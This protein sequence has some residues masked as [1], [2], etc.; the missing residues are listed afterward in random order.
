MSLT[1]QENIASESLTPENISHL[2]DTDLLEFERKAAFDASTLSIDET[3]TDN[4]NE[5]DTDGIQLTKNQQIVHDAIVDFALNPSDRW[6][7]SVA[8]YAGTGKTTVISKAARHILDMD[9]DKRI[10]FCAPTGKAAQVMKSK[11]SCLGKD[12]TVGTIHSAIYTLDTKKNNGSREELV[13][14]KKAQKVLPYDLIIVD[15][16]SMLTATVFHDILSY[17]IPVIFVGDPGQLPPVEDKPVDILHTTPFVLTDVMRQ[18]LENPIVQWATMVRNGKDLPWTKVP[19]AKDA[20]CIRIRM[21]SVPGRSMLK[22]FA[23]DAMSGKTGILCCKNS[24]RVKLNGLVRSAS[25]FLRKLPQAGERL[26]CLRNMKGFWLYNG[27]TY[28]VSRI[29]ECANDSCYKVWLDER[30][31]PIVA[32]AGCLNC[33]DSMEMG[34]RLKISGADIRICLFEE[35]STQEEAAMFDFGYASTVH[36]AQGSEW[37]TVL[38]YDDHSQKMTASEYRRW[39]YTGITRAKNELCILA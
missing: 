6:Y 10:L 31:Y 3:R 23:D 2:T 39:L 36:K 20:K 16:A 28:T 22:G 27:S 15:E 4:I 25:G 35:T 11:L 13:F 26:M 34:R 37:D 21:N 18:A 1:I 38:F 24:L 29:E 8:G 9:P 5:D 32:W 19:W 30:E 14:K 7:L 17:S 12:S 33:A